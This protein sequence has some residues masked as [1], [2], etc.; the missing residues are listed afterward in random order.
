VRAALTTEA[1]LSTV[2]RYNMSWY[3]QLL[4]LQLFYS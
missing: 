2:K 3:K 4:V 1:T